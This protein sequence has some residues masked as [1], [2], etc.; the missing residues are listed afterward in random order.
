VHELEKTH[1]A[2]AGA[3]GAGEHQM[4]EHRAI[5]RFGRSREA[6]RRATIGIAR[7]RIAARMIVGKDNPALP[8]SAAS[9]MIALKGKAPPVSSPG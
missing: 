3:L 4:I 6:A 1:P 2:E 7:A 9:M 8:C 5:E